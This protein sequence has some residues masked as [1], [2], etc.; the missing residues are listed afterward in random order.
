MCERPR[1]LPM[2]A[3]RCTILFWCDEDPGAAGQTVVLAAPQE[4]RA[5]LVQVLALREDDFEGLRVSRA[6]EQDQA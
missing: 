2:I 1:V 5:Q 3:P 6:V 4:S